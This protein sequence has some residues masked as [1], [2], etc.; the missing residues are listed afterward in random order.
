[1][2]TTEGC[3]V[4]RMPW[5]F[6]I[7]DIIEIHDAT[8]GRSLGILDLLLRST[9]CFLATDAKERVRGYC[10]IEEDAARGFFELQDIAVSPEWRGR[11]LGRELILEAMAVCPKIK[12]MTRA[13]RPPVVSF[14]ESLGFVREQLVENYYDVGDDALRMCW[15]R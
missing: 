5:L 9:A 7:R 1:M 11:G 14:F 12:I 13:G 2:L 15:T 4:R 10:F 3:S 6:G 8:W